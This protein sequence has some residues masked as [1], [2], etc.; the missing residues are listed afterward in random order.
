MSLASSSSVQHPLLMSGRRWFTHRSWHCFA[1]RWC[2]HAISAKKKKSKNI[3][4]RSGMQKK[5]SWLSHAPNLQVFVMLEPRSFG[6][7]ALPS[8]LGRGRHLRFLATCASFGFFVLAHR[9]TPFQLKKQKR[10]NQ[11][12]A[13]FFLKKKIRL[14]IIGHLSFCSPS[15]LRR[16][17][18]YV[19][20]IKNA[21][22]CFNF[23]YI[24]MRY[25]FHWKKINRNV[26]YSH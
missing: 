19:I 22:N 10:E 18:S 1:V 3:R 6:H 20:K 9:E 11:G 26:Y 4:A 7:R 14:T 8:L 24:K 5:K 2:P 21:C 25:F 13:I 15:V 17:R 16:C 12:Q 23:R